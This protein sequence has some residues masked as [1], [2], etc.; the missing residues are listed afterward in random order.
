MGINSNDAV[1]YPD[2]SMDNMKKTAKEKSISFPYLFD[3]SQN[4][5]RDY[6]AVCTP[7]I[8]VYGEGRKLLY[9][10]R[11]DD[12][13]ERPE[14]VTQR[15]LRDAIDSILNGRAVGGNQISSMGC[16]IKWK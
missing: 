3:A 10:G 8:Y 6:D 9:R 11:I 12:N 7:D 5:A 4:T 16:S 2:D 13:W 14:K 1:K 15:D